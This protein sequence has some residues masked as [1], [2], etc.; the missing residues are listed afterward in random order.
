[1]ET[2]EV[3]KRYIISREPLGTANKHLTEQNAN[4]LS[5]VSEVKQM[6][7][8]LQVLT[9]RITGIDDKLETTN[10]R[11]SDLVNSVVSLD[12][13]ISK[14]TRKLVA[15]KHQPEQFRSSPVSAVSSTGRVDRLNA[16][17]QT[18]SEPTS[19]SS[20]PA[21]KCEGKLSGSPGPAVLL[22]SS[23]SLHEDKDDWSSRVTG[24]SQILCL[25][26]EEDHPNGSWL[27]DPTDTH[28]RVRVS[29]SPQDLSSLEQS[30][31]GPEKLAI[32]LIDRLFSR[33]TLAESNLTGKGR[34]KKKQLDPL[35]ILG[36]YSHLK[37]Q[38]TIS[39]SDWTRIKN[40]MEAKCRFL[41]K[42]KLKKLPLGE[43]K[44]LEPPALSSLMVYPLYQVDTNHLIQVD[45]DGLDSG[46][47]HPQLQPIT[48]QRQLQ[49]ITQQLQPITQHQQL[50]PST[51]QLQPITDQRQMQQ[52]S[53][54]QHLHP[55]T[56][57]QQL[58]P[59]IQ[60]LQPITDQRQQ[61]TIAQR[62][63]KEPISDKDESKNTDLDRGVLGDDVHLAEVEVG[64]ALTEVEVGD[65]LEIEAGDVLQMETGT[66]DMG[67]QTLTLSGGDLIMTDLGEVISISEE[68]GVDCMMVSSVDY[69]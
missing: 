12:E 61:E 54:L 10:T 68:V 65:A 42:R 35:V 66:E 50:R 31:P 58:R 23:A 4:I 24:S 18:S 15:R 39:E 67:Q 47:Q 51:Q 34:L 9:Q 52:N 33:E 6:Q 69:L 37:Y 41:W 59:I 49:P 32:A 8:W 45:L 63:P 11:S 27:G 38:Y 44:P 13:K 14:F 26:K 48:D 30:Q 1:M 5:L 62:Q 20:G 55:I 28:R 36:I 57:R 64:D 22:N 43:P 7:A 53:Q 60:Q 19:T 40:N 2:S 21:V 17:T 46:S 16:Q 56:Q 29:L 3:K 25:N